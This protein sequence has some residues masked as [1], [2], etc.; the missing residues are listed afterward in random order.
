MDLLNFLKSVPLFTDFE[1]DELAELHKSLLSTQFAVNDVILE[2]GN[3]NRAL[4]VVKK[5]RVRV[6]R[7]VGDTEVPLCDLTAGQTFG[8][9][10][11]I[12]DGVASATLFAITPTEVMS[13]S[14]ND[15]SAFLRD[16]PLA[17]SKFWRAVAIDLRRRLVST[18]DV[19]RTYFEMNRALV[20][21]PTFRDAY[22]M[23]NR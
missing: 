22:A 9:L 12:D 16:R 13:I 14:L 10:S 23:C 7:R 21:N 20:E 17:A 5:G 18:N 11:I 4:H 19:V 1:P 3:A 8:E 6:A 15:L 2:E